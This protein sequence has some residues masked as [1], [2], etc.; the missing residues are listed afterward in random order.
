MIDMLV[1]SR[2]KSMFQ[3]DL[4]RYIAAICDTKR[5]ESNKEKMIILGD[6][7]YSNGISFAILGGATNRIALQIDGYAVKFAMD[8]Q[9][10]VDNLIEYSLSME[11]QPYVTKSYETNGYV[12]VA[13]CVEVMTPE[14]FQMHRM[15]I[16]KILDTLCQDYLLGDVG[17]IKLNM[18]NWGIRNGRPVMLDYAYCHRATE[19][20]FTCSKC[21]SPLKYDSMYDKLMCTD[22][23]GCKAIYTYNERKRIQGK[24]VDIDMIAERKRDS[25]RLSGDEVSKDIEMFEDRLVGNN[26]F[27]IDNPSDMHR[28][29]LLEEA[30]KM[31]IMINGGDEDMMSDFDALVTLAI[32]PDNEEARTIING[33]YDEDELPEAIYTENY[34]ENYM[35]NSTIS[36]IRMCDAM[37]D[38]DCTRDNESE[39]YED[40]YEDYDDIEYSLDNIIDSIEDTRNEHQEQIAEEERLFEE[41]LSKYYADKNHPDDKEV[42]EENTETIDEDKPLVLESVETSN[43]EVVEEQKP[44]YPVSVKEESEVVYVD[45]PHKTSEVSAILINGTPFG[46][47]EGVIVKDAE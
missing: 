31:K 38:Y 14:T 16:L 45:K 32:D 30:R 40:D 23:S 46:I 15:E 18:T 44:V 34:Q 11:L 47:G 29:R 19:N 7:L 26:Y 28:Y 1:K 10:Y 27:I 6:L 5:I 8:E 39:G 36:G 33:T 42:I 17:Y 25:I 21:G 20:L 2:I 43:E 12:L 13:E 4:L 41:Q 9:G 24:Q 35:D 37:C 22:R 3:G